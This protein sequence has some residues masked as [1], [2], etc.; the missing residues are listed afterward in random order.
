MD[1]D[2]SIV[3]EKT[4]LIENLLDQVIHKYTSP[5]KEAFQF[6]QEIL[7]DS[8]IISLGAKIRVVMAISQRVD[9]NLKKDPLDKVISFRNAFAHHSIYSHPTVKV[10]KTPEEDKSYFMLQTISNSGKTNRISRED[11]LKKFEVNFNKAK[12]ALV[13]LLEAVKEN[14][15]P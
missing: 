5:R 8:S 15:N 12:E 3:I 7:L 13:K 1:N 9:G 11:A 14:I 6:F 10:G 4:A 2:V